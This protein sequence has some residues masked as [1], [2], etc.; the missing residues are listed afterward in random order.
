[1]Q[2]LLALQKRAGDHAAPLSRRTE[3]RDTASHNSSDSQLRDFVN[4]EA[5]RK[6]VKESKQT[7]NAQS[8][9]RSSQTETNLAH[10]AALNRL[11]GVKSQTP[12]SNNA[13]TA[14]TQPVLV[15]AYEAPKSLKDPTMGKRRHSTHENL[16]L[17]SLESF[18]FQDILKEIDPEIK[19]SVDAIAEI[20]GRSKL[21]LADEYGSHRPPLG[22]FHALPSPDQAAFPEVS[23]AS[24]LEPVEESTPGHSRRH[25]LALVGTSTPTKSSL[26]GTIVAAIPNTTS[27]SQQRRQ[28][29]S[30]SLDSR[31]DTK[32]ALLPYILSW[33]R[34]SHPR[35][36]SPSTSGSADP[37]AL[38]SLHKILGDN[39]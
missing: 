26:S 32:V 31:A 28:S 5:S 16:E 33:L 9:Q 27:V 29:A 4:S 34:N 13:S 35:N 37:R 10:R 6:P 17:P 24:R 21:S 23:Q 3:C 7:V 20:Y 11:N 25:S 38:E 39:Q 2:A 36:Y 1:M 18:S 19:V 22:D 12:P 30:A 14:I 15:K 8:K